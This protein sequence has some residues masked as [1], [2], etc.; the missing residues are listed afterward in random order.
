MLRV[1]MVRGLPPPAHLETS[2]PVLVGCG[3]RA[4]CICPKSAAAASARRLPAQAG[5]LTGAAVAMVSGPMDLFKIQTQVQIIRSRADSNYK[6]AS[7]I[8]T[9][10]HPNLKP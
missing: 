3:P 7:A 4:C 2:P 9:P 1:R 10:P 5:A 6:R 8:L